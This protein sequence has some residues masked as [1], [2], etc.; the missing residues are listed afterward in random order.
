MVEAVL[1]HE[2]HDIHDEL[3]ES[4]ST[5]ILPKQS[6]VPDHVEHHA[7]VVVLVALDLFTNLFLEVG[8]LLEERVEGRDFHL[9]NNHRINGN[10]ATGSTEVSNSTDL[11]EI[12]PHIKLIDNRVVLLFFLCNF[13]LICFFSRFLFDQIS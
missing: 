7:N 12:F 9:A 5:C 2:A 13:I 6:G 8:I 10:N 11:S 3:V 4:A 1:A